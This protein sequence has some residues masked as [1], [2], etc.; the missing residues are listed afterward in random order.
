MKFVPRQTFKDKNI[1][2]IGE[3]QIRRQFTCIAENLE[4]IDSEKV[5][6]FCIFDCVWKST[7]SFYF[8]Q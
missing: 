3:S 1:D 7:D 6:I 8:S 4:D 2:N 5:R